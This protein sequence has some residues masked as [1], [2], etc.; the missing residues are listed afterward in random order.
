MLAALAKWVRLGGEISYGPVGRGLVSGDGAPGCLH[1]KLLTAT[2]T[3][4]FNTAA[5]S[6]VSEGESWRHRTG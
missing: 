2:P 6:E 3:R 4:A 5:S 1:P